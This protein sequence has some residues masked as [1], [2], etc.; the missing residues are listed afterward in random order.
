MGKSKT[1]M[2]QTEGNME[3]LLTE[4]LLLYSAVDFTDDNRD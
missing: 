4:D 3:H 1:E 2:T